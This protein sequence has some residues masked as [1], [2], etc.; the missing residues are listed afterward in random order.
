[1]IPL[2]PLQL[3]QH[4]FTEFS[5][6]AFEKGSQKAE[7]VMEPAIACGRDP[8]LPNHWRLVLEFKLKSADP[9]K[10]FLYEAEAAILGL[11][12][13]NSGYPEEKREQLAFVNGLSLLYS[14]LREMLLTVTGRCA[15]GALCLPTLN[16]ADL[17]AGWSAENKTKE[18]RFEH[19]HAE[20]AKK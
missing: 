7:I 11:I 17:F 13:V 6:K 2:S 1:M 12:E 19:G 3:K 4:F 14:A 10:P 16:F 8:K 9:E 5:V 18:T 15:Q 20:A